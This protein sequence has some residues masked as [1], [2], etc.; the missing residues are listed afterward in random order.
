MTAQQVVQSL[1]LEPLPREGGMVRRTW[2]RGNEASAIYY[3]L[4]AGQFSHLHRLNCDEVYTFIMGDPLELLEIT[5]D[6]TARRHILGSDL[7]AGQEPQLAVSRGSWQGSR[8]AAGGQWA[9]VSTVCCPAYCDSSYEHCL[10]HAP[11]CARYPAAA[12]LI[13]AL[14]PEP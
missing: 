10:H 5:A 14:C 8:L 13:R 6:G 4:A 3:L 7:A 12:E 1:A 9:L 2:D 11:L